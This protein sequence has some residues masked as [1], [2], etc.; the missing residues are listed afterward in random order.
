MSIKVGTTNTNGSGSATNLDDT[1][2]VLSTSKYYN[3]STST[4]GYTASIDA[5]QNLIQVVANR[6]N[7][8]N[9]KE[10]RIDADDRDINVANFVD[11]DINA[12]GSQAG[13]DVEVLYAKRGEVNT[14]A[15]DDVIAVSLKSNGATNAWNN[16]F[17]IDSGAG[18]DDIIVTNSENSNYT[19]LN[20][21]AGSGDDYVDISE[22]S[23]GNKDVSRVINGGSGNDFIKGSDSSDIINGGS[24]ND[25]INGNG[26]DDILSG[27]TGDDWI[28]GGTGNDTIDGGTGS[29]L[30]LGGMGDDVIHA[31]YGNDIVEGGKGEDRLFGGAGDDVIDGGI[32]EDIIA[33]GEGNDI[34]I[35]SEGE[36]TF[37]F[38]FAETADGQL[39]T[40][41]GHDYILDIEE[42]ETLNFA[43]VFDSGEVIPGVTLSD[44]SSHYG[45][46]VVDDS[47]VVGGDVVISFGDFDSITLAGLGT[48]DS[49]LNSLLD[50]ENSGINIDLT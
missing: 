25:N 10:V 13:I 33:G 21:N 5:D 28:E 42:G 30:L 46:S 8:Y 48:H 27:G 7:G 9:T 39:I 34:L 29:D 31:G 49:S 16:L 22:V 1:H 2:E 12:Q 36:D 3:G 20:I 17:T 11:V 38:D 6:W 4:S 19:S 41:T 24:E 37:L 47:G 44:F 14:G 15:G 23:A 35:G 40:H 45:I 26:G 32:G 43:N 50:L 18:N